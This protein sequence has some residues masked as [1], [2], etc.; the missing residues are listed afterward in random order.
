MP[1]LFDLHVQF[2]LQNAWLRM[3]GASSTTSNGRAN[4]RRC[5]PLVEDAVVDG[6][7][8]ELTSTTK[9]VRF[10]SYA[11]PGQDDYP[12]VIVKLESELPQAEFL[13]DAQYEYLEGGVY[14]GRDLLGNVVTQEVDIYCGTTSHELTRALYTV[15]RSLMHRLVKTFLGAGYIDVRFM[16]AQ[17]LMPDERLIAED[18]GVFVRHMRWRAMAQIEAHP[19]EEGPVPDPDTWYINLADIPGGKVSGIE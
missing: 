16:S 1:A 6:W 18:A 19:I 14:K 7:Y 5:F 3:T 11:S 2:A 10:R 4:F 9:P 15:I 12:L 8:D 13:G 17:E